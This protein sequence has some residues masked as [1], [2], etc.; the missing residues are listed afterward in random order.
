[1]D[2]TPMTEKNITSD[3]VKTGLF[4]IKPH[5]TISTIIADYRRKG[6]ENICKEKKQRAREEKGKKQSGYLVRRAS[7]CQKRRHEI[8]ASSRFKTNHNA[9]HAYL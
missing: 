3:F 4:C 8:K 9:A 6:R 7:A 5:Y 1:M 2:N